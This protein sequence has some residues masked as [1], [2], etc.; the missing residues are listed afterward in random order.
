MS[1]SKLDKPICQ[2]CT[3]EVYDPE[4]V[5]SISNCVSKFH[6][7][8]LFRKAFQVIGE[9]SEHYRVV[10][11]H[12]Y[13]WLYEIETYEEADFD[14]VRITYQTGPHIWDPDTFSYSL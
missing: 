8:I 5:D 9:D 13:S 6:D 7:S 1:E 10:D 3:T 11:V 14:L 4:D 2:C 12:G